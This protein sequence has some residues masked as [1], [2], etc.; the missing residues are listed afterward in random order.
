M[1]LSWTMDKLG[2]LARSASDCAV[3]FKAIH[4]T[5]RKDPTSVSKWFRWPVSADL[6]KL[7]IGQV[8]DAPT[9]AEDQVVLDV[10]QEAGA[11]IVPITLPRQFHEWSVSRMLDV[12]AASIFHDLMEAGDTTGWNSWPDIFRRMHFVSAVDYIRAARVR[13]RLAQEMAHV[14]DTVDLYVGGRDLGISNLT[15]H[16]EI[17]LP[18]MMS[19]GDH[20]QPLCATL[21]GRLYDEA[22][23]LAVSDLVERKIGL[24]SIPTQFTNGPS[25]NS[26]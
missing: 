18:S 24:E 20:A 7:R 25:A 10:L 9:S 23:L 6:S 3:V 19:D 21:T 14:F 11:N 12:E 4:G 5:D 26:D 16:P 8:A 22:T 2:P 1:T 15:G 17:A 13:T